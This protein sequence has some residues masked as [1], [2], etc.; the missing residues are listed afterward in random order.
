MNFKQTFSQKKTNNANLSALFNLPVSNDLL[1]TAN[2]VHLTRTFLLLF[3]LF[4]FQSISEAQVKNTNVIPSYCTCLDFEYAC[5]GMP[6]TELIGASV[7][8]S[9]GGNSYSYTITAGMEGQPQLCVTDGIFS[10]FGSREE[11]PIL[12]IR[13]G[14]WEVC[15]ITG[16]TV[17]VDQILTVEPYIN[18][19]L[20][21]Y[22]EYLVPGQSGGTII[23]EGRNYTGALNTI[24]GATDLFVCPDEELFLELE[25][26]IVPAASGMCLRVWITDTNGNTLIGDTYTSTSIANEKVDVSSLF[27]NLVT[28]GT[29]IIHM[30]LQCC[31]GDDEGCFGTNTYRYAYINVSGIFSYEPFSQSGF[32]DPAYNFVPS[33]TPPGSLMGTPIPFPPIGYLN[34]ITFTGNNVINPNGIEIKY[35]WWDTRCTHNDLTDDISPTNEPQT[36]IS[37]DPFSTN[38]HPVPYADPS[39]CMCFRLDLIYDD[40][41]SDTDVIDSYYYRTNANCLQGPNDDPPVEFL[42]GSP[43][44]GQGS[45]DIGVKV[46]PIKDGQLVLEWS[47][48]FPTETG[49]L[50]LTVQNA[51]GAMV[52]TQKVKPGGQQLSVPFDA[53]PGIYFYTVQVNGQ[54]FSG[55]FVKN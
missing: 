19:V 5:T 10:C 20:L 39:D 45:F 48:E 17:I 38:P 43:G 3:V 28:P 1:R 7:S 8:I 34:I 2:F 53:V 47:G 23:C 4:S 30:R 11:S 25:D 12:C 41:C 37:E 32:D 21:G 51:A 13:E 44:T 40:G 27:E 9:C 6:A 15:T 35:R 24:D 26:L 14:N 52:M 22:G 55:K 54:S 36:V 31:S 33:T 42:I 46:N 50:D 18:G 29:Y 16:C 49:T